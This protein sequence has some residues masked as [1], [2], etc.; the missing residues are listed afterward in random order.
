LSLSTLQVKVGKVYARLAV[1]KGVTISY[2]Q[3]GETGVTIY[4][5]VGAQETVINR[6]VGLQA[7][8]QNVTFTIPYQTGCTS[9]PPPDSIFDVTGDQPY[10]VVSSKQLGHG[11]TP[12]GWQVVCNCSDITVNK[13]Y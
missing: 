1:N 6:D 12:S 3:K 7:D 11:T 4:G 2:S 9:A 5:F 13:V 10:T 8:Q